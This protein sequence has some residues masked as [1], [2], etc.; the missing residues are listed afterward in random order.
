MNKHTTI[1]TISVALTLCIAAGSHA[2]ELI[3]NGGFESGLA[4]WT[5]ADSIGSDGTFQIQSGTASNANG[6]PVAAPVEGTRAAMT[7]SGGPGSHALFQSFN[8]PLTAPQA[9]L[10]FSLYIGNRAT[11]FSTPS[12]L[13]WTTPTLNQ[14]ARVDIMTTGADPFSTN[15]A[16]ILQNVFQTTVGS[17]LV[18]G[19]NEITIDI[20][21]LL[22]AHAGETLRLR[23]AEADNVNIFNFGVDGVSLLV[24]P[25]PAS[26]ALLGLGGLAV[27]ARRRRV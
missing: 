4:G 25:S 23:F 26:L 27:N 1:Q 15:A 3:T 9:T 20:T 22:A 19:Y 7:D 17:P 24:V 10:R 13:D 8:V 5:T 14:Q 2:Q 6:L 12:T 21:A 11:A 18:T 16:D